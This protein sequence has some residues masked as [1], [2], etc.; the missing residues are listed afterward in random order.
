MS[1]IIHQLGL[2]SFNLG[3]QFGHVPIKLN[4]IDVALPEHELEALFL[5]L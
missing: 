2:G 3:Q 5:G 1:S 4:L